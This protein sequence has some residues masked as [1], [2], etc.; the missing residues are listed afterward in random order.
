ME[1]VYEFVETSHEC[2]S[3]VSKRI[4]HIRRDI[5]LQYMSDGKIVEEARDC[6][7]VN[8]ACLFARGLFFFS[9]LFFSI[10]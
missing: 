6:A 9:F 7:D 1:S 8:S 3:R 2:S 4:E 10:V 5:R